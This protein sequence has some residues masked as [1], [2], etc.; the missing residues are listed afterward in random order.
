MNSTLKPVLPQERVN[1]R[2]KQS[3]VLAADF[4]AIVASAAQLIQSEL[5]NH[6]LNAN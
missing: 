4:H 6:Q 5:C 3:S 2:A 1:H